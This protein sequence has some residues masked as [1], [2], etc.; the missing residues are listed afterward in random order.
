MLGRLIV[1]FGI[2]IAALVVP[3]YI[4]EI[5]PVEVRGTLVTCDVLFITGGQFISSVLSFFLGRN[6]RLMLGLAGIPSFL[7]LVGMFFLPE[8]PR[9]LAKTEKNDRCEEVLTE[10]Y[11]PPYVQ[12]QFKKLKR[13]VK[14]HKDT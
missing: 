8:T 9:Y 12:P 5:A 1:G 13:E 7:Q 6:W 3:V 4:S 2:G 10:V 14:D 11:K